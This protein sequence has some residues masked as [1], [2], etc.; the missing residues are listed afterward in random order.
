MIHA[1]WGGGEEHERA[2]E[3]AESG[4]SH[5]TFPVV[6]AVR[7]EPQFNYSLMRARR[8]TTRRRQRQ[9]TMTGAVTQN[10]AGGPTACVG[11]RACVREGETGGRNRPTDVQRVQRT[12]ARGNAG[13]WCNARALCAAC[14]GVGDSLPI[15]C[16]CGCSRRAIP[17]AFRATRW[18]WICV[19]VRAR[20]HNC[21]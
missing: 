16:R 12:T 3:S 20:A 4:P 11:V 7:V 13:N 1:K 18:Q 10:D 6:P 8:Q 2:R 21:V 15:V 9:T 19:R 14:T 17:G 5:R